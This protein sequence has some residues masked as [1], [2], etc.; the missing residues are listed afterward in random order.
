MVVEMRITG[1]AGAAA[2]AEALSEAAEAD[3]LAALAD[4]LA[5]EALSL[6]A[7]A[8]VLAALAEALPDAALE[9]AELLELLVHAARH[10]A[11]I[12]AIAATA[13][14]LIADVVFMVPLSLSLFPSGMRNGM[15]LYTASSRF[16]LLCGKGDYK[17]DLF[18]C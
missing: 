9:A 4:A 15:T 6:A 1:F 17:A 3:A 13:T 8:D 10:S 12:A 7:D 14:N 18:T 2:D 16:I 11:N 5:A